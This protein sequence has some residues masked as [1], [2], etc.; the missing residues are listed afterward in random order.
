M[1]QWIWQNTE[2][3]SLVCWLV[4]DVASQIL[5]IDNGVGMLKFEVYH[6]G[7]KDTNIDFVGRWAVVKE[8]RNHKKAWQK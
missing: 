5:E 2:V 1:V 4:F 3:C 8:S 6:H 7:K